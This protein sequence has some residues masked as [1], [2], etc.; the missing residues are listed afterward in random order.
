M[1]GIAGVISS[2][3]S[4]TCRAIVRSMLASMTRRR[5]D[6]SGV[7][8]EPGTSTWIGWV[9][10][11]DSGR[12]ERRDTEQT[13]DLA[14]IAADGP[15]SASAAQPASRLVERY[16]R[17]G[18][19]A[20]AHFDGLHSGVLVDRKAGRTFVFNDPNGLDRIYYG[21]TKDGLF[22]ASEAKAL[23]QAV[24]EFRALDPDGV[25]DLIAFGCVLDDRTLFRGIRSL[26][27]GSVSVYDGGQRRQWRYVQHED[28]ERLEPLSPGEFDAAFDEAF[29]ATL[30]EQFQAPA[31]IGLS[32]TGGVD[33]RL[34]LAYKP[35]IPGET[36]CYTFTGPDG[37]MRDVRV[38]AAV[39]SALGLPHETIRIEQN[40]F[41]DFGT[42]ADRTVQIT[43]GSFGLSGTHEVYLNEKARSLAPIRVGGVFGGELLRGVSSLTRQSLARPLLDPAFLEQVRGAEE[44]WKVGKGHRIT[45]AAFTETPWSMFGTL[46]ACRSQVTL[47]A[48]YL[49]KRVVSLAYRS[50]GGY[51]RSPMWALERIR[52]KSP[53]LAGLPTDRGYADGRST[54]RMLLPRVWS[55]ISFKL[56]YLVTERLSPALSFLDP[57]LDRLQRQHV[58]L[59]Q[60][61]YLNYR[62]WFRG[63][64][65]PYVSDRLA[66]VRSGPWWNDRVLRTL[67]E[68]HVSGK[69]N[70]V[71]EISA[72]LTLDAVERLLVNGYNT[73][74]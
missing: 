14:V 51:R 30:R 18:Q 19:E 31:K 63:R 45:S 13:T 42:F 27:A 20:F 67:A 59:G 60:H 22:F 25:A 34:I 23:L 62:R 39:A 21:Q 3:P 41:D 2:Q 53:R 72:V 17:E 15:V 73:A 55:E 16:R 36:I 56:D 48:P 68:S 4:D 47:R 46:A 54:A 69:A 32:L 65:A 28:L 6:V 49:D 26:P 58:V 40:F 44:R 10:H 29:E 74:A 57:A 1:A 66:S 64:L 5:T 50:P 12:I 11:N 38:A 52:R 8:C 24:P 33:S 70:F 61:K 71:K 7:H 35:E 37:D 43:D 9:S